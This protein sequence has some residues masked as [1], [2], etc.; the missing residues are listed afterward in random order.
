VIRLV[1]SRVTIGVVAAVAV[2]IYIGGWTV[3]EIA[4]G[5]SQKLG[6]AAS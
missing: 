6:R 2:V 5:V 1:A 3:K 4:K